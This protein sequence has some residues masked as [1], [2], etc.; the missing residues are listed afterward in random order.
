MNEKP[1]GDV[2]GNI[3]SLMKQLANMAGCHGSRIRRMVLVLDVD[4]PIPKLYTEMFLSD[5]DVGP[6][7]QTRLEVVDRTDDPVIVDEKGN[8]T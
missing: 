1:E 8:A 2:L 7:V 3:T 5:V 4:D 6:L